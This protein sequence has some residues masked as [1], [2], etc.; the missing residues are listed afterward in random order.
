MRLR[1]IGAVLSILAMTGCASLSKEECLTGDWH[2]IG[3][4]DGLQGKTEAYLAEHQQACSE[5]K[6]KL[7]LDQY[8]T[9][10]T[11]GLQSYCKPDNGYRVGRN[12]F[13]YAYVCPPDMETAF[14]ATYKKGR[15]FYLQEQKVRE[16]ERKISQHKR[17][18][19]KLD[20]DIS[21]KEK[22]LVSDGLSSSERQR[23]LQEIRELEQKKDPS[24]SYLHRLE[25][26]L[27]QEKQKLQQLQ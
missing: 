2:G 3:Y 20:Q 1:S 11:K 22:R 16:T 23:L 6:V 15:D 18:Q 14:L 4:Q 8:L 26:Q 7:N 13:V 24:P 17:E 12:G 10:R 19:E 27:G 25:Y 21:K 9:G 5:H